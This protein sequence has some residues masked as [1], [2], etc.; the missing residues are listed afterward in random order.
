MVYLFDQLARAT[1]FWLLR[2]CIDVIIFR[3]FNICLS[4]LASKS[5]LV[6]D[7]TLLNDTRKHVFQP[8][9]LDSSYSSSSSSSF[10]IGAVFRVVI[11]GVLLE[12]VP[13]V[14]RQFP[15]PVGRWMRL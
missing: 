2:V 5:C 13:R 1:V 10:F 11:L 14:R 9:I 7:I 3:F 12:P 15:R 8:L 6:S 4:V